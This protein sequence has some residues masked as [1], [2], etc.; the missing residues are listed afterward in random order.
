MKSKDS[1]YNFTISV[2]SILLFRL[3]IPGFA[4]A[5]GGKD[6]VVFNF[7]PEGQVW[8][9]PAGVTAVRVDA[10]GAQGGGKQGGKGGHVQSMLQVKPGSQLIIHVGSQPMGNEGGYNGGGKG[11]GEGFGGGGASDIRIGGDAFENRVL[12]AGGGGG[13]SGYFGGA[14]SGAGGGLIGGEGKSMYNQDH[15]AIGGTQE[16]GGHGARAYFSPAGKLGVGGDGINGSG[17]CSN[18]RMNGGGGGYYGGGSGGAGNGGG[19]SSYAD[20]NNSSVRHQQGVREG[21][22]KVVVYW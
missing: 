3:M 18:G 8:V 9:V 15:D 11:C 12:V 6:S 10:Y 17:N 4:H 7:K 19:G 16:A 1:S 13:G 20:A 22:G 2:V 14:Q 5:Q 21:N